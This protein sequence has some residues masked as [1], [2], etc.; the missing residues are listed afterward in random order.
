MISTYRHFIQSH[1]DI[2]TFHQY[3]FST[4]ELF[5]L[6]HF[7]NGFFG[8]LSFYIVMTMGIRNV[9]TSGVARK[10]YFRRPYL[11]T[12]RLVVMHARTED[13]SLYNEDDSS[14]CMFAPMSCC[15]RRGL[16]LC[17]EEYSDQDCV[18]CCLYTVYCMWE[19]ICLCLFVWQCKI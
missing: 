6:G 12:W 9:V 13:V 8:L 17:S 3:V 16:L 5:V 10:L 18:I 1:F 7:D 19:L 4:F 11:L 14:W 2:R 15:F